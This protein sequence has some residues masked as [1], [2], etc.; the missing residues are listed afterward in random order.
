MFKKPHSAVKGSKT[1]KGGGVE[2]EVVRII[3]ISDQQADYERI[4]HQLHMDMRVPWTLMHCQDVQSSTFR[5]HKA[6]VILLDLKLEGNTVLTPR[7]LFSKIDEMVFEIPIIVLTDKKEEHQLATY[8]MEK[9]AADNIIRGKFGRLVDAIEFALIRQRLKTEKRQKNAVD[10]AVNLADLQKSHDAHKE[11]N[12]KSHQL[13]S[14]FMGGY[15]V[16]NDDPVTK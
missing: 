3:L 12:D 1:G 16:A 15:S 5:V 11:D 14:M 8:V 4:E 9:G 6:D 2:A 10:K 7:E 13:L